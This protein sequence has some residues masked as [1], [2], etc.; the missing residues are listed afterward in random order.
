MLR[1]KTG[2]PGQ[3]RAHVGEGLTDDVQKDVDLVAEVVAAGFRGAVWEKL[4]ADLNE[5]A[6]PALLHAMRRSDNGKLANLV[7]KSKTPL[8]MTDEERATL[9]HNSDDRIRLALMTISVALETFP[10]VLREGG[11]DPAK[12]VGK[13][14]RSARLATFFYGRCGLV[15]PRVSE[16]WRE[17]RVQL[18]TFRS[19]E[20]L[21]IEDLAHAL[22]RGTSQP[23][24]G[25]EFLELSM[26]DRAVWALTIRGDSQSEI[27]DALGIKVGD[28]ENARTKLRQDIRLRRKEKK[29]IIPPR[30]IAEWAL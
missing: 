18:F 9:H 16:N 10:K 29:L 19:G 1:S 14:G 12:N 13:D 28:V 25:D 30:L 23:D 26:R 15:F 24:S 2:D 22:G 8:R 11:Y 7:A 6:Y 5:Y 27:A 17:E 21:D 20:P 3:R 4:A